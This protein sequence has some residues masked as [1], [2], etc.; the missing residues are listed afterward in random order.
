MT[1]AKRMSF[2]MLDNFTY[3]VQFQQEET[4]NEPHQTSLCDLILK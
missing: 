2:D 4:F 1:R 3:F